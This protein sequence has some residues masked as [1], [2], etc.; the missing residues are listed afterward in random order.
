MLKFVTAKVG[1]LINSL[2]SLLLSLDLSDAETGYP[3]SF[4]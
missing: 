3:A 2:D 4:G 1:I